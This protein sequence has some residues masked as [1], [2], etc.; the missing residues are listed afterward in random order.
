MSGVNAAIVRRAGRRRRQL[1]QSQ[2]AKAA[3]IA[4]ILLIAIV[5]TSGS[6][7][8]LTWSNIQNILI[9]SSV[10]GILAF[11][12]TM[13]MVSGGID[14]S[15]GSSVSLSGIVM[16]TLMARGW[17]I[18]PA[19]LVGVLVAIA[20]GAIVGVLAANTRTHPFILTLGMSTLVQGAALLV[21]QNPVVNLPIGFIT[22]LDGHLLGLP[23]IVVAFIAVGLFVHVVLS[24][25]VFGRWLYGIGASDSA[26]RLAGIRIGAVKLTVYALNGLLVGL[27]A[28][29]L[30]VQLSSAQPQQGQGLEL[31][32]IA[33]VAV[34]G[35]P[36]AGGRGDVLGTLLGVLLLGLIANALNLLS[37]ANQWQYVL[38]GLVIIVAVMA[39]R[40]GA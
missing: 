5:T 18:V 31:S 27:A 35:T 9:Q 21:S 10:I 8:F 38:Q 25:T 22:L 4:V 1:S 23:P 3:L 28:F 7:V 11:G 37:I 14:L 2:R 30:T 40:H 29:L 15:V 34:G 32:A 24:M 12:M 36:L 16:G 33:A 20:V 39:Q 13:L 19:I 6:S 26:A 17:A